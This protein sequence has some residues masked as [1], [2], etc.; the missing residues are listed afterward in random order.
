[1][2]T[3]P[4]IML[5]IVDGTKNGD[6]RR[7][8]DSSSTLCWASMFG[9]PPIPEPIETPTRSRSSPSAF[10]SPAWRTACAEAAMPYWT[11]RSIFLTSFDANHAEGSKPRTDAEKRVA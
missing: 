10:S 1:M 5:M 4:A 6:T 3:L 11:N 9:R 2:D 7:G 8:P